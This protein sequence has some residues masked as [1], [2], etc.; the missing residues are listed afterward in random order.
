MIDDATVWFANGKSV[1]VERVKF[2]DGG[3]I[4]VRVDDSWVYYPPRHIGRVVSE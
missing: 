4:G 1:D 2:K 3:W